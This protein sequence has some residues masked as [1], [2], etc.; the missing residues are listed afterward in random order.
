MRWWCMWAL[1][2]VLAVGCDTAM[3]PWGGRPKPLAEGSPLQITAFDGLQAHLVFG[4][5]RVTG[6]THFDAIGIVVPVRAAGDQ[7]QKV[8]YRFEYFN[9]DR[10]PMRPSMDWRYILLPAHG[11]RFMEGAALDPAAVDWRLEVRRAR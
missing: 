1:V 6:G 3:A 7:P 4:K 11:E 2:S 8:Q 9:Q 5:P 10:R